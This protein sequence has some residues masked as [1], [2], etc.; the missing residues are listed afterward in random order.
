MPGAVLSTVENIVVN[1]R[2]FWPLGG[3]HLKGAVS[4]SHSS[5]W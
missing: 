3:G 4:E 1:E 2:H 5:L